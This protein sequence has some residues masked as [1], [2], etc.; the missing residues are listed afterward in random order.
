MCARMDAWEEKEKAADG[1]DPD[2]SKYA[3]DARPF[4]V[5]M[6]P[7]RHARSAPISACGSIRADAKK[8]EHF[9]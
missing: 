4:E 7:M 1:S 3:S 2:Y 5:A 8:I 6:T 9:K